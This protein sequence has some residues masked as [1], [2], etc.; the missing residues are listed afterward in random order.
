MIGGQ[1]GQNLFCFG[2]DGWEV[3][4]IFFLFSLHIFQGV[5]WEGMSMFDPV[6][7]Q[8]AIVAYPARGQRAQWK[9][10]SDTSMCAGIQ[11]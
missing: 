7:L 11:A 6:F 10:I 8:K 3:A 1:G 9:S 5:H 2:L 4:L